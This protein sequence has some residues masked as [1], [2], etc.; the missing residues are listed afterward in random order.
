MFEDRAEYL[1]AMTCAPDD[2]VTWKTHLMAGRIDPDIAARLGTILG[3]SIPKP[4]SRLPCTRN[5]VRHKPVRRAR[6]DPYY[7][8][9]ARAHPDLAPRIA[10][11]IASMD[12]PAASGPS[13][14]GTSARR[15]SW[16]TQE[17]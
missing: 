8:T 17:D 4:L 7:R 3:Y 1:F 5:L 12:R 9:A 11:L 15:T 10:R 6:V 16:C 14:W 2:A 13:S